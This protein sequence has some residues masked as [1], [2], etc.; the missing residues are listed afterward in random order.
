MH[1]TKNI[2]ILLNLPGMVI[3]DG[4]RSH[5]KITF[6]ELCLMSLIDTETNSEQYQ[7]PPV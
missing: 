5:K 3:V 2:D 6:P 1:K 4:C 7:L